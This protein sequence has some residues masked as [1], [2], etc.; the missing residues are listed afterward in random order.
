MK[1][2]MLT[3]VCLFVLNASIGFA[4][5]INNLS[6][7]ETAIGILDDSFYIEH[8]LSDTLTLGLQKNDIYG[9]V[10]LNNNFRLIVG[11]KDYDSNSSSEFYAGVAVSAPLAPALDGYVALTGASDF[12]ELQVGVNY[13]LTRN[14]DV[15]LNYRSIMPDEGSNH[16]RTSIGA[17]F[18]F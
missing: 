13:N 5:P 18:K 12:K 7:G 10:A 16:N 8:K 14:F 15:N 3:V 17:T 9:Q 11:S 4:A 6:Q 1:K 2:T